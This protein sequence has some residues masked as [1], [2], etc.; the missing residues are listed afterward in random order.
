MPSPSSSLATLRPDLAASFMEYDLEAN[1]RGFIGHLV[2]RVLGVALQSSPF[3]KIPIEQLLANPETR[4]A[5]WLR[6]HTP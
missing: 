6:G 1:A 5:R 2:L 3:G 4:R